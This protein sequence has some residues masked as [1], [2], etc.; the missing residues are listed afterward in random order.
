MEEGGLGW[1]FLLD[2]CLL[3]ACSSGSS[4]RDELCY[5]M[6]SLCYVPSSVPQSRTSTCLGMSPLP[7]PTNPY[8]AASNDTELPSMSDVYSL[9]GT[10]FA[11]GSLS[12]PCSRIRGLKIQ[13]IPIHVQDGC[14]WRALKSQTTV[15]EWRTGAVEQSTQSHAESNTVVVRLYVQHSIKRLQPMI[16]HSHGL[17]NKGT[18]CNVFKK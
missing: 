5:S 7:A 15:C 11:T 14:Q 8:P 16:L 9:Q 1:W 13:G 12:P 18:A 10:L 3:S 2:V 17:C 6:S 4:G